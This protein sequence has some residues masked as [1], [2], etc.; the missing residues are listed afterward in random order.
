LRREVESCSIPFGNG[1]SSGRTRDSQKLKL[2]A[3]HLT[4]AVDSTQGQL[5]PEDLE[6]LKE[7][8]RTLQDATERL[9]SE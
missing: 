7:L 9:K 1:C 6:R 8:T 2:E 5:T 3:D 4:A